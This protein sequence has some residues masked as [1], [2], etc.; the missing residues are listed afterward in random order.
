MR[1]M[2]GQAL[3]LCAF[4][5][6]PTT[7]SNLPTKRSHAL[8][9]GWDLRWKSVSEPLGDLK[10]QNFFERLDEAYRSGLPFVAHDDP[11]EIQRRVGG[12][13]EPLFVDC[14]DQPLLDSSGRPTG[15]FVEGVDVTERRAAILAVPSGVLAIR[16]RGVLGFRR[17]ITVFRAVRSTLPSRTFGDLHFL[18]SMWGSNSAVEGL[19]HGAVDVLVRLSFQVTEPAA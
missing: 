14:V 6:G 1:T 8:V 13:P 15:I 18:L 7:F 4:W 19:P 12:P 17:F 11:L 16:L 5:K 2:F 10:G 9:G 3:G